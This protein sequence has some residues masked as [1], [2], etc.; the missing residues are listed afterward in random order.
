MRKGKEKENNNDTIETDSYFPFLAF[1]WFGALK[2]ETRGIHKQR[3][4]DTKTGGHNQPEHNARRS[5]HRDTAALD[6][7][8]S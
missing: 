5:G 7:L 2:G 6:T 4:R 8:T 3:H 1:S